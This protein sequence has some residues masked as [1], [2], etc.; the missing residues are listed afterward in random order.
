MNDGRVKVTGKPSK[1]FSLTSEP[2]ASRYG[3]DFIVSTSDG[4]VGHVRVVNGIDDS[5]GD[6]LVPAWVSWSLLRN[7]FT[8]ESIYRR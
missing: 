7:R 5:M 6:A 2:I 8:V 3:I 4:S 1:Y